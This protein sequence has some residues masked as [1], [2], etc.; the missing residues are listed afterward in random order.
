MKKQVALCILDGWGLRSEV[1]GNAVALA[2]TPNFDRLMAH[3][4]NSKLVT[5]GEAV[6]LP[7]GSIGNSEVGHLHIGAGRV[8]L[9]EVQRINQAIKTGEF[10]LMEPL[11]NLART[12]R[13]TG[14]TVHVVG[15]VSDVGV[16]GLNRHLVA[17]VKSLASYGVK[18]KVHAI[19]DGRDAPPGNAGQDIKRLV[20]GIEGLA[21]LATISG[22]YF[23]MDR[24]HRW[25]RIKKA[26]DA[27]M[28][29]QG[30]RSPSG[31]EC[32]EE[33]VARGETDE[34]I[35]PTCI[36]NFMGM[37]EGDGL[38]FV[39][40]RSDRM[41]ELSASLADPDFVDFDV[42]GRPAIFRAVSMA[43][44]F[45]PPR[46]WIQ[47]LFKK[48]GI[49]NTLGEWV[50]RHG[51]TQMRIAE[52]EKF[53]HVTFFLNGGKEAMEEGENRFM[54]NSPKVATYD[55][56]PEMSVREVARGFKEA[57]NK[58]FDLIVVNIAN[59]DMVGHTGSLDA[60]IKACEATDE[61][62]GIITEEI[63]AFGGKLIVTADHG[64]CEMMVDEETGGV[65]TAHTTNPV[66]VILVSSNKSFRLRD[67][68]SLIDLAPTL[69]DL[70]GLN[71]PEQM[72]GNTL[73]YDVQTH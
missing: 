52:T 32:V 72:T 20:D 39:N 57:V 3:Y 7:P 2:K 26:W 44:Y 66:P 10:G 55:L 45:T 1:E 42:T 24:D 37:K 69:L 46:D 51:L 63:L 13:D 31:P 8:I 34:F 22:R 48:T 38:F 40:F 47:P 4:P 43:N 16:H 35:Q 30:L 17:S 53:P 67:G 21:E 12:T 60:A 61:A 18:V 59:P 28:M 50:A 23:A 54:P 11:V 5:H 68:G 6:G 33:S 29:G 62:L 71:K 14:N 15:I 56:E 58:G 64:N 25:E 65:H 27:I 73:I 19:T 70:L 41:R 9:M 49:K 36:G